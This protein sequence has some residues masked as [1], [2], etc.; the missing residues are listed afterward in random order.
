M[1]LT[2][3]A[4]R[5][6]VDP[7][8]ADDLDATL[9]PMAAAW[10]VNEGLRTNAT[11]AQDY[12][13]GRT[14]FATSADMMA[15]DM[16]TS[17]TSWSKVVTFAK[18]GQSAHNPNALSPFSLAVDLYLLLNGVPSWDYTRP[19]W[20]LLYAAVRASPRLHSGADFPT[21]DKDHVEAYRFAHA[22]SAG[23]SV[24]AQLEANG[25]WNTAVV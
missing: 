11:Q 22:T 13:L 6:Q 15:S 17:I 19:E 16:Y 5:K 20:S 2:W 12:Q 21:P 1:T 8:L 3:L 23:P 18:P 25:Q 10:V 7:Q 24:V 9:G 14:P 4:D